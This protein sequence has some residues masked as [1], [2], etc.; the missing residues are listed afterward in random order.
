MLAKRWNVVNRRFFAFTKC[1]IPIYRLVIVFVVVI[2]IADAHVI[3]ILLVLLLLL[4]YCT[5]FRGL[6]HVISF[7][8]LNKVPWPGFLSPVVQLAYVL[9]N[10]VVIT[11]ASDVR[12][13]RLPAVE[14]VWPNTER[15]V[16]VAIEHPSIDGIRVHSTLLTVNALDYYRHDWHFDENEYLLAS[17]LQFVRLLATPTK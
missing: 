10:D 14:W 9:G 12:V 16:G 2:F 17:H 13:A 3:V 6:L 15:P 1:F 11:L 5:S 7:T 8:V 4:I